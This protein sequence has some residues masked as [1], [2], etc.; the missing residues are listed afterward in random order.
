MASAQDTRIMG[1]G[2]NTSITLIEPNRVEIVGHSIR[3]IV[4][5]RSL[6]EATHLLIKK[7]FPDEVRL[8][9][10]HEICCDAASLPLS[11]VPRRE[12]QDISKTLVRCLL[13]DEALEEVSA[14]GLDGECEKTVFCLGRVIRTIDLILRSKGTRT[15]PLPPD[16]KEPFSRWLYRMCT[17]DP[18]GDEERQK[19]LQALVVACIDHGLTPPSTQICRLAATARVPYEVALAQGVGAISDVHGG[20]S[21]RAAEFF[22]RYL[23]RQKE[24]G[25]GPSDVLEGLLKETVS[26]GKHV[27]GLGHRVHTK[28]PRCEVLWS[29]AEETRVAAQCVQA[30]KAAQSVFSRIRGVSLPINVDG[31]IGAIVADMGLSPIVATLVFVLG[32][33]AGLSAHYFEEVR[34]FPAMRWIDFREAVYRNT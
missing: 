21:G 22:T 24:T 5:R 6:P 20:A 16:P 25:M 33:V 26:Q 3:E 32:R 1:K 10:L 17:G 15:A 13:E 29:V 19:M 12:H 31:V 14:E 9:E 7:D 28:D 11:P 4:E 30:S 34:T 8:H 27:P 18:H 2:W 23:K